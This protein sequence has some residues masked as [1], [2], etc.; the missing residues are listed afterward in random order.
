MT[1]HFKFKEVFDRKELE[2]CFRFRYEIHSV[3]LNK[4]V[5]KET[6]F[7]IDFDIY[8]THSKHYAMFLGDLI[9]GYI[10]IVMPRSEY[11]NETAIALCKEWSLPGYTNFM[12]TGEYAPFPFLSYEGIPESY[13]DYF[14]QI[15][16][17]NELIREASRLTMHPGYRSLSNSK[18]LVECALAIYILMDIEMPHAVLDCNSRHRPLYEFYGFKPIDGAYTFHGLKKLALFLPAIPVHLRTRLHEMS[19]EYQQTGKIEKTYE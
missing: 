14:K 9:V 16:I 6:F 10:R 3:S 19:I 15:E 17:K 7:S 4:Y 18:F 13:W 11:S 5:L 8:D 12:L 2:Y 1:E